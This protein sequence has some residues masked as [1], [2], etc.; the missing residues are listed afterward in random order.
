[1]SFSIF[2]FKRLEGNFSTKEGKGENKG[3]NSTNCTH[4]RHESHQLHVQ[5]M[6]HTQRHAHNNHHHHRYQLFSGHRRFCV[7]LFT[8]TIFPQVG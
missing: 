3:G 2:G 6:P 7:L 5:I 1:M 4:I 8:F